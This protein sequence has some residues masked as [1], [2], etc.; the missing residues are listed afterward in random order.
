MNNPG[1]LDKL[2]EQN[3]DS[4]V[5]DDLPHSLHFQVIRVVVSDNKLLKRLQ[6][7]APLVLRYR[8]DVFLSNVP[9]RARCKLAAHG[10][11][12]FLDVGV[13]HFQYM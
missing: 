3:Q 6:Q 9:F 4:T 11:Q 7:W 8:V 1:D 12:N 2:R 13:C 5:G 10:D